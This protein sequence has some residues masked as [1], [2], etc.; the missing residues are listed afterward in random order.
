[1]T[2]LTYSHFDYN[3]HIT[4][5]VSFSIL[6]SGMAVQE[7]IKTSAKANVITTKGGSATMNLEAHVPG[8]QASSTVNINLNSGSARAHVKA[9]EPSCKA[10]KQV[11]TRGRKQMPFK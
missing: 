9:H 5:H 10:K 3:M 1:M 6:Q 8:S 11:L 2:A 4:G 7:L